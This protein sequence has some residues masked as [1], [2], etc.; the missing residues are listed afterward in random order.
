MMMP[1]CETVEGFEMQIGVNHMGHFLLTNLLLDTFHKSLCPNVY[2]TMKYFDV[3]QRSEKYMPHSEDD[4]RLS[5]LS[6]DI[7]I[8]LRIY[9]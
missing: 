3:K 2:F 7:N 5:S 9:R 4:A 1:R 8:V 6:K